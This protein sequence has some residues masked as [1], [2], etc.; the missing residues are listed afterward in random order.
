MLFPTIQPTFFPHRPK[1][2]PFVG[3]HQGHSAEPRAKPRTDQVG[4]SDRGGFPLP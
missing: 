3:V 2:H 4:G 1:G